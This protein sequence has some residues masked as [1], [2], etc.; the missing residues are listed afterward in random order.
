[1]AIDLGEVQL[2]K[3]HRIQTLEEAQFVRHRIPGLDGAVAQDLGRAAVRFQIE[4][5]FYGA[6]AKQELDTLRKIYNKR[7][8]VDFIADIVSRSYVGKVLLER[9]EALEDA[10]DPEQFSYNL[11]VVEYVDPAG[12]N[13]G[14]NTLDGAAEERINQNIALDAKGVKDLTSLTNALALG[15]IPE[16]TNPF[17][18]LQTALDPVR[19]ALGGMKAATEGLKALF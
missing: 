17:E 7:E 3:I 2:A 4:G 15:A 1:M 13:A 9:F 8:P 12:A 18:P 19:D 6:K 5:I 14:T 11:I 10:N 16:I